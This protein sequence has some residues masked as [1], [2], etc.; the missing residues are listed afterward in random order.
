[1]KFPK[2]TI[3]LGNGQIWSRSR[4]QNCTTF[5]LDVALMAFLGIKSREKCA[6]KF[7]RN[8]NLLQFDLGQELRYL[9]M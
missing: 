5:I 6:V 1:M 2:K 7:P 9:H 4:T 8:V 3:H